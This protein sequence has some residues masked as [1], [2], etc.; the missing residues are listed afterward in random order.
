MARRVTAERIRPPGLPG[1]PSGTGAGAPG[2]AGGT[3]GAEAL[4]AP[5]VEPAAGP[6]APSWAPRGRRWRLG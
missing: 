5:G 3:G 2:G 6:G 1:T 4:E